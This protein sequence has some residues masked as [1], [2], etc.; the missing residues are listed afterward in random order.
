MGGLGEDTSLPLDRPLAHDGL[1]FI[2]H[3]RQATRLL[4]PAR[5]VLLPD[6]CLPSQLR[7]TYCV[8]AGE[9]LDHLL[10][11]SHGER[12]AHVVVEFSPLRGSTSND[13]TTILAQGESG[14]GDKFFEHVADDVDWTV[15]GTHPLA[16]RYLSKADFYAHTF[17]RLNKLLPGGTQLRVENVLTENDWA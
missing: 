13:A 17:A 2:G 3:D 15:E 11:E 16:G 5:Q 7:C 1:R 10:L 4:Q 12:L 14:S 6:P 8:V 9:P